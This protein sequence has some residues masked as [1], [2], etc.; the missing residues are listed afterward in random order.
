[1]PL[2]NDFLI[3]ADPEFAI[4][5]GEHLLRFAGRM[6]TYVP[7][8]LDHN[9]Y[10][11]EPH[12]KPDKSVRGIIQNLRTSLNDF[13][14]V[15][16]TG[17][18]RAG[19]FLQAPERSITLGGHVH[20]D[21][22]RCTA[23]Q[24]EA[25]DIFTGHLESLDIL[26]SGECKSRR[27]AGN[28]GRWGDI[29]A[30]HGHF[31]Y[32]TLPSWLF[33]QRVAKICLTG[34]KLLAVDPDAARE[35]LGTRTAEA[36]KTKLTS[37]F[38][39]FRGKDEDADWILDS[40]ML[41][42]KLD[43]KPDRDLRDVWKVEP[44]K[45]TPRWKELDAKE[46]ARLVGQQATVPL[47]GIG[48]TV[49]NVDGWLLY[50]SGVYGPLSETQVRLFRERV[51]GGD[52]P[53]SGWIY[54]VGGVRVFVCGRVGAGWSL[55]VGSK[56]YITQVNNRRYQW[57]LLASQTVGEAVRAILRDYVE[58]HNGFIPDG[59]MKRVQERNGLMFYPFRQTDIADI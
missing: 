5:D 43:V 29:R 20:I 28:Y 24:S 58:L 45:E 4:L 7:W 46:K 17:K 49:C 57:R 59:E 37:L 40:G 12:P 10:A 50:V 25:L 47:D 55:N 35:T 3:G 15:A 21:Q 11:I 32:R 42:K 54:Q 56:A 8:G 19:A 39:R 23:K 30:E 13:A 38:E 16:P 18:W 53:T 52:T 14:T 6:D 36:S 34:T 48:T 2:L 41:A 1:M 33:S 27:N 44:V 51:E 31:E 26:P 9:G 22:P